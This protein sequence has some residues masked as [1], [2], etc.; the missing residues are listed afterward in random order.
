M[1]ITI[2]DAEVDENNWAMLEDA[3]RQETA[4]MPADIYQTFLI[5]SASQPTMWRIMTHWRS[6]EDLD[7]MRRSTDI[8]LAVRCS[9]RRGQSPV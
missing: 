1:V 6:Q 5:Q 9:R 2:L 7:N 8:P 3:Y 4:D